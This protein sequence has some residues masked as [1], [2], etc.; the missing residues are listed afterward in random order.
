[1]ATKTT[2]SKGRAKG[3]VENLK[4]LN[5]RPKNEVREV[6]RK[7]GLANGAAR[8]RKKTYREIAQLVN[9]LK[10]SDQQKA[11]IKKAFPEI[12]TDDMVVPLGIMMAHVNK[13]LKGD[14][15]SSVFL[16]DT[17]GEKPVDKVQNDITNSDGSFH[18][19][20]EEL[21]DAEL[22]AIINALS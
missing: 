17:S 14:V 6:A 4:P 7:G 10:L 19:P 5:T 1:M 16:R 22:D 20:V 21:T 8:R 11:Q 12:D 3:R 18:R 2:T 9:G 13:A 15:A